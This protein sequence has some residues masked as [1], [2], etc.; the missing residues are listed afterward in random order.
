MRL[1]CLVFLPVLGWA[2][3]TPAFPGAEGFGALTPGG[4]GGKVLFV[5][6]LNDSGPGSLR[7]ALQTPGPRIVVF[8]TG[9]LIELA[10]PLLVTEPFLTLAGQT[11]PG[12]GICLSGESLVINTHDVVVRFIRV[13]PGDLHRKEVDA[14]SIGGASHDVILDH[15][16]ASW[17]VD[18][19]L[20]PSGAIANITV[21]WSLI[22]ESL[23]KSVHSKGPHGYGT[24]LRAVGGVSLHHNLWAHHTARNPR[25]GDN[26]FKGEPTHDFRNNVIYDY[27]AHC[28]G[29]VDGDLRVNYVNNYI[30]PGPSSRAPTPISLLNSNEK[31]R[32]YL[33]GNILDGNAGL[34]GDNRRFLDKQTVNG[35]PAFTLSSTPFPA[36]PLSTTD[37][38]TALEQVLAGAGATLPRRDGVDA[39]VVAQ[40]RARTGRIIDS[41]KEVGG[42]PVY[43]QG[44]APLDTDRDGIPDAW[45]KAHGLDPRHPA[46]GPAHIEAYLNSLV[47]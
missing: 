18:E 17:S 22:A 13:R 27:G 1:A 21:Q 15:V 29:M 47:K 30:R 2:Q 26:Y 4:R 42:W 10:T 3:P 38:A 11:A 12:D 32:F 33:S 45:E 46:D 35:H 16:S 44:T 40:V 31:T 24:L 39:R 14:V 36:P 25:F 6:N 9:G 28:S 37:A 20:S 41:Q 7:A 34:T 19:T 5:S 23:N 43:R 8:E